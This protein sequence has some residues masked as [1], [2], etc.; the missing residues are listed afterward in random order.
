M[1]PVFLCEY[2]HSMGNGPGDLYDY[3]E[4]FKK[5]PKLIMIKISILLFGSN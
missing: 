2:S 5:Y 3:M 1:R 4:A